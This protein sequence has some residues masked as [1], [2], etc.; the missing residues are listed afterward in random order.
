MGA[1]PG[2][3]L[4]GSSYGAAPYGSTSM[5]GGG[6]GGAYGGALVG[7]GGPAAE[8]PGRAGPGVAAGEGDSNGGT[9]FTA[10][11][12][13]GGSEEPTLSERGV[14]ASGGLCVLRLN[15]ALR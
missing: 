1:S 9:S 10:H 2:L 8:A 3:G 15:A 7:A 11:P 4:G 6:G 5:Y 13:R 12:R 14:A